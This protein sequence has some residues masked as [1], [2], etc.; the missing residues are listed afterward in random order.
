MGET[1]HVGYTSYC[2]WKASYID[3]LSDNPFLNEKADASYLMIELTVRNNDAKARTVPPFEL[4]D[5]NNAQYETSSK[6][7]A[8]DNVLGVME[9]LNP[10]VSKQ[11][12]LVFDVPDNHQY[13]LKVSG[14]YWSSENALIE[15]TT[16]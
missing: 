11:G 7:W 6:A 16:E 13:R 8:V 15:I 3:R 10:G 2:V 5:E 9:S 1:V 12:R 4:V 14:G